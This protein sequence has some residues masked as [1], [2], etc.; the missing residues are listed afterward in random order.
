MYLFSSYLPRTVVAAE[1]HLPTTEPL[2]G[3]CNLQ[4]EE[5]LAPVT[6]TIFVDIGIALPAAEAARELAI[7]TAAALAPGASVAVTF[8]M[9]PLA[10]V[11]AFNPTATHL[12]A[13]ASPAHIAVFPADVSIGPSS[14]VRLRM[15]ED[16]Y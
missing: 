2:S 5:I 11:F 6:E 13:A 12:Y 14:T 1:H 9:T 10:M 16:A 3:G 4:S 7:E 8:A 15:L